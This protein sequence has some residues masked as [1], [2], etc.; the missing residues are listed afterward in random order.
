VGGDLGRFIWEYLDFLRIAIHVHRG[1]EDT[2]F[3]GIPGPDVQRIRSELQAEN[4]QLVFLFNGVYNLL[5]RAQNLRLR[6]SYETRV[7]VEIELL[8]LRERL[9][10]PSLS[11][12]LGRLNRLA[13]AINQGTPYSPEHELQKQFLGTIVDADKLPKFDG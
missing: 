9:S 1:T 7:L 13:S 3:L 12:I 8:T 10:R 6:N 11:G 2:D 4:A 5:T